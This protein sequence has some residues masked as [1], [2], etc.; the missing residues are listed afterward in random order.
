MPIGMEEIYRALAEA[1]IFISIGTSGNVYPAAG[2]V[3]EA[4]LTGAHTVELNLEPSL[5]ESQFEEK[6]YGQASQIVDEYVHKLFE[7]INDPKADLTQ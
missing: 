2:F 6:H 4:R 5:V 1:D 3:H 7:L